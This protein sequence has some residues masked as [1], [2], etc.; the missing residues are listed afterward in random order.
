VAWRFVGNKKNPPSED[1]GFLAR[2]S[3][4]RWA[5]LVVL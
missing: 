5:K 2:R 1:G 4:L 3:Y